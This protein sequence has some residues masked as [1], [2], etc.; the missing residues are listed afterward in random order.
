MKITAVDLVFDTANHIPGRAN[1]MAYVSMKIDNQICI[2]DMRVLRNPSGTIAL[3]M[4]SRKISFPC[5]HC[6]RKNF[7][8]ANYCNY[9]GNK[10]VPVE[11]KLNHQGKPLLYAD[12]AFPI[13]HTARAELEER[14]FKE[15]EI[16]ICHEE[17]PPR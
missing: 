14:I 16:A 6:R 2:R 4:P 15:Y 13:C 3:I 1:V 9:C 10:L 12:V 8:L 17:N 7:L 11:P 5:P